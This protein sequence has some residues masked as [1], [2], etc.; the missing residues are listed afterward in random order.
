MPLKFFNLVGS[1]FMTTG[2]AVDFLIANARVIEFKY[3]KIAVYD[4]NAG[5]WICYTEHKNEFTT[6][7]HYKDKDRFCSTMHYH[8][9]KDL[10][11]LKWEDMLQ[12]VAE[13]EHFC[14]NSEQF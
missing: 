12:F 8:N 7:V 3:C 11:L 9:I 14:E 2:K 4:R 1:S 10:V 6:W 13:Y 5:T